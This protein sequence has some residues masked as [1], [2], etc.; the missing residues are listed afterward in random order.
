[1]TKP[2]SIRLLDLARFY[3]ALPH[4]MAALQELEAAIN[5]SNPNILGRN[6]AWFKTWSQSGKIL[7]I[8]NDWNGI[9]KAARIA[10]AKFP[11]LIAAQWSLESDNGRDR[12]STRLNSS[13]RT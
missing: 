13:H 11:E 3:R 5:K 6:Q 4:Q 9:T 8:T 12:K 10:G 7:E 2:N 1:M